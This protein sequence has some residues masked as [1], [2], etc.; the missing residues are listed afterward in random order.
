MTADPTILDAFVVTLGLDP[1]GYQRAESDMRSRS[2]RTKDDVHGW[3]TQIEA[4]QKRQAEAF[5]SVRNEVVGL[6]LAF[7]GASSVKGFITGIL[8]ASA[9]T[10]R[11]ADNTAVTVQR[12]SAWQEAVKQVGGSAD[13]ANA[14]IQAMVTA[15]QNYRLLG[16]TGHDADFQGLGITLH[17]LQDPTTAL[18]KMAEAGERLTK[19]EFVARLQRIGIP[20]PTINLLEMGRAKLEALLRVEEKRYAITKRDADASR[21]LQKET[22]QLGTIAQHLAR[23]P[24]TEV[25]EGLN[26]WFGKDED[27]QRNLPKLEAAITGIG[28]AVLAMTAEFWAVPA[29]IGAILTAIVAFKQKFDQIGIRGVIDNLKGDYHFLWSL[30]H[31]HTQEAWRS[32]ADI[33]RG[34]TGLPLGAGAPSAAPASAAPAPAPSRGAQVSFN[35][36]AGMLMQNG[37]DA[38]HARAIAA[39]LMA[40][41]GGNPGAVNPKSGAYGIAQWLGIRQAKFRRVIGKDLKG[42]S[43]D[44]QIR[45]L[46]WELHGGDPGGIPTLA[47][48]GEADILETFL[49][50]FERAGAGYETDRDRRVGMSYLGGARTAVRG[51]RHVVHQTTHVGEITI[52]LTGDNRAD[53][54]RLI[55]E[56]RR[57]I[58]RRGL[59]T[60]ANGGLN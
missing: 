47:A 30:L 15:Q 33:E 9:A 8:D 28:I 46:L 22:A 23:G 31:G 20:Q 40:E 19:P 18:L 29:A 21:Q 2:K 10:G 26:A 45:Y 3:A 60:Q 13:D 59:V 4:D 24:I 58:H 17:D 42:S 25:V 32:L 11:L 14:A 5:R 54:K 52:N 6:Y 43:L 53:G 39:I 37:L 44:D 51:G 48:R 50:R 16:S 38:P 57:E 34:G 7:A 41:S 36:L 56:A 1:R 49:R 12:L 35:S 27:L 55:D